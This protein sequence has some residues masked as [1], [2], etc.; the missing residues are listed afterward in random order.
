MPRDGDFV[1]SP[2]RVDLTLDRVD[3]LERVKVQMASPDER[4]EMFEEPSPSLDIA[5]H[6]T[7]LDHRR[8]LPVLADAFVVAIGG[9]HREDDGGR[10]RIG[11]QPQIGAEDITLGRALFHDTHELTGQADEHGLRVVASLTNDGLAVIEHYQ[12][13]IARVIELSSAELADP[14]DGEAAPPMGP[15]LVG[16]P[17][18]SIPRGAKQQ[19]IDRRPERVLGKIAQR[20]HDALERP[21]VRYICKPDE[22]RGT[23]LGPA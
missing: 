8:T 12:V 18:F 15:F 4:H 19:V 5:R 9:R 13:D 11:P 2:V 20:A 21:S 14:D 1:M 6:G 3:V 10:A 22:Q 16:E 23:A 7:R 17:D